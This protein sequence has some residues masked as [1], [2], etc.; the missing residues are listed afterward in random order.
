MSRK[1]KNQPPHGLTRRDFIKATGVAGAV[2]WLGPKL[3]IGGKAYAQIPGGTLDPVGVQKYVTP[4]LIPP[5]MPKAGKV[6]LTG[7]KNGDY[8]EI[9]VRQF[10]QQILAD[11]ANIG[12]RQAQGTADPAGT[13]IRSGQANAG[14]VLVADLLLHSHD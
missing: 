8:Y 7:G 5:V 9:S 1:K 3:M 4:L 11:I 10:Q 6:V 12:C 2:Y 13:P 14:D